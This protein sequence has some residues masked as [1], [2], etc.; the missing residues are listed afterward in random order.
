MDLA[1]RQRHKQL[2]GRRGVT[3]IS[4]PRL[5]AG[6]FVVEARRLGEGG[7]G[8]LARW[9]WSL[10][11]GRPRRGGYAVEAGEADWVRWGMR[12]GRSRRGWGAV[13]QETG[14]D[15]RSGRKGTTTQGGNGAASIRVRGRDEQIGSLDKRHLR[16]ER[17]KVSVR[18]YVTV[19]SLSN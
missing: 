6:A 9:R 7:R 1:V 12:R 5:L 3:R 10:R 16:S 11:A 4:S 8:S 13:R 18:P 14:G 15:E 2:A 19:V 17:W